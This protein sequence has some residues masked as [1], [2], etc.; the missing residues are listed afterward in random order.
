M[1][2]VEALNVINYSEASELNT[3]GAFAQ[4]VPHAPT[5]APTRRSSTDT[6][7]LSVA[8]AGVSADGGSTVTSYILEIDDGTGYV[9]VLD[10][11]VTLTAINT[12]D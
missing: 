4:V 1:A 5:S 12:Y 10:D 6:T 11:L 7:T 3:A 2:Q 8:W 9:E